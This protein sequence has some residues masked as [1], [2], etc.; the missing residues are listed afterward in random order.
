MWRGAWASVKLLVLY[1]EYWIVG[2]SEE[3]FQ[4][5]KGN[6][7]S[8]LGFYS[9]AAHAYGQ[10]LKG[11]QSPWIHAELGWCYL[12]MDMADKA[13]ESL[14]VAYTRMAR[15][16]VGLILVQAF[17]AAGKLSDASRLHAALKEAIS[18]AA[19]DLQDTLSK[20]QRLLEGAI[21]EHRLEQGPVIGNLKADA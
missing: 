8:A 6:Q 3:G 13:V 4:V 19:S 5:A 10:A 2:L 16:D 17:I 21:T 9:A 11:T 14:T 18:P 7:L 1:L 15:P 12:N 20:V